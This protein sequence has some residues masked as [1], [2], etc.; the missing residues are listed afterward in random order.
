MLVMPLDIPL[1]LIIS[2]L[3]CTTIIVCYSI[4]KIT[5][6]RVYAV[7]SRQ[8]S[9][10]S[11][12]ATSLA[13]YYGGGTLIANMTQFYAGIFWVIWRLLAISIPFMMLSYLSIRMSKFMYH[14][15]MP[16]TMGRV[17]GNYTRV[18]TALLSVPHSIA[19]IAAQVYI[20]SDVISKCINS[21]NP[22]FIT[23]LASIILVAYTIFGGS[24]AVVLTDIGSL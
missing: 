20:L 8:F 17:Y 15:S 9:T 3:I 5:S 18:I 2:F 4:R 16:E 21:V 11:L 7:G 6:F 12:V 10:A 1:F 13:T 23:I 14:I 19:L 24:R 22:V